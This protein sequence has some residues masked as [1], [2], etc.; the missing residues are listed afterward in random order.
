MES[1]SRWIDSAYYHYYT[2]KKTYLIANEIDNKTSDEIH[3]L[4]VNIL[5]YKLTKQSKYLVEDLLNPLNI[6]NNKKLVNFDEIYLYIHNYGHLNIYSYS[7]FESLQYIYN[8]YGIT[9]LTNECDEI[10]DYLMML[11]IDIKTKQSANIAI[12]KYLNYIKNNICNNNCIQCT[13]WENYKNYSYFLSK[14]KN[15]NLSFNNELSYLEFDEFYIEAPNQE[16]D[17]TELYIIGDEECFM[18]K[19]SFK[20]F[21]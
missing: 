16:L 20:Y 11:N 3:K 7:H 6:Y 14:Y 4:I 12:K 10:C 8:I 13:R 19:Y 15:T 21:L 1:R 18:H 17:F 5:E 2:G 9:N